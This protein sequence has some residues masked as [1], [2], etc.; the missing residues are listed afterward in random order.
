VENPPASSETSAAMPVESVAAHPSVS[1]VENARR[2]PGERGYSPFVP[3]LILASVALAWP[4]FQCY[5]LI[6][7]KRLFATI[8]ANQ[9]KQHDDSTKLRAALDAVARETAL[10]A[11]K[12]NANAKLIVDELARRGVTI[13]PSK[14]PVAPPKAAN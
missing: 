2:A 14:P 6:V 8:Y 1:G 5:Q 9:V 13:D 3:L 7:E 10:L 11:G 12:G 4:S